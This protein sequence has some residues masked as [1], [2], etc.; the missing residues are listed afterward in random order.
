MDG[1]QIEMKPTDLMREII[2]TYEKHGWRLRR[3]LL[4]V[5]TSAEVGEL[6]GQFA[7]AILLE[8]PVDALWFSRPSHAN[9]EAW[10]LRLLAETSYALFQTFVPDE[11][12]EL[13]EQKRSQMEARLVDYVAR[14]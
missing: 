6:E 9:R 11:G 12:E 7:N 1:Q 13:R 3:V 8:S 2:A 14:K 10:E 5:E 4:R